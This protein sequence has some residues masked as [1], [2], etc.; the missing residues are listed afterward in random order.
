MSEGDEE[1]LKPWS[2]RCIH[3]F[4]TCA[5]VCSANILRVM[6]ANNLLEYPR[7]RPTRSRGLGMALVVVKGEVEVVE[8]VSQN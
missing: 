2:V 5:N 7:C 6:F 4:V 3:S 8:H 1:L